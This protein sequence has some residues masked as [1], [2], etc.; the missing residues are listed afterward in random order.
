MTTEN[1]SVGTAL[2]AEI[3]RVSAKRERW[4]GYAREAGP[5]VNFAP[6][7]FF[8]TAAIEAGKRA[9]EEDDGVAAI[10]ALRDLRDFDSK[11]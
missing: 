3:E 4:R 9:I 1:E 11:D 5:Q 7:I 6:A 2:L 10:A 8:M